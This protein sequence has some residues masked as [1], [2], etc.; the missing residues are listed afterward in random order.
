MYA[1]SSV[2]PE[3]GDVCVT[4]GGMSPGRRYDT[5]SE[6]KTLMYMMTKCATKNVDV[7]FA[8]DTQPTVLSCV[9][10]DALQIVLTSSSRYRNITF[11]SLDVLI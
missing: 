11:D 4:P 2:L 6:A 3:T 1:Y 8:I 7:Y 5:C 9:V 10:T